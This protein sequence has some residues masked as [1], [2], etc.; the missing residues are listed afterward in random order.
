MFSTMRMAPPRIGV[1]MS[2]GRIAGTISA[3]EPRV[4]PRGADA[5]G[6]DERRRAR[7]RLGGARAGRARRRAAGAGAVDAQQAVEVLAPGRVHGRAVAAV[8]LEQVQREH[9]VRA[10]IVDEG[11]HEGLQASR[12]FVRQSSGSAPRSSFAE[13]PLASSAVHEIACR[14]GTNRHR[15]NVVNYRN[16]VNGDQRAAGAGARRGAAEDP[17]RRP[18]AVHGRGL[19]ARHHAAHR[20]RHRVL[21]HHDLQPLQGQ[22][23]PRERAVPRGVQPAPGRA[24]PA[25]RPP[26]IPCSGSAR[27]APP[28]RPS[29]SPTRTTTASCS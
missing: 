10:E 21:P 23:R 16:G 25:A 14:G 20:R 7:G 9:V 18:R 27:S 28:T 11:V 22:G 13:N 15:V 17:R 8:L 26:A 3:F 12:A 4:A 1:A 19:R 2:P 24:R 6:A 29:A 5:G